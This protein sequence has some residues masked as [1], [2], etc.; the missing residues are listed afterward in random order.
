MDT[1]EL[2]LTRQQ[3]D[4]IFDLPEGVTIVS[5]KEGGNKDQ[6]HF[7][8]ASNKEF[9]EY[10]LGIPDGDPKKVG[11]AFRNPEKYKAVNKGVVCGKDLKS[12]DE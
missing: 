1:T 2:I 11:D 7:K 5:I 9:P 12:E 10:G 8:I 6:Y 3:L 4:K